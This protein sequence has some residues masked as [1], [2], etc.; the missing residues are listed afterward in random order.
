[1]AKILHIYGQGARNYQAVIGGTRAGLEALRAAIDVA[2][3]HGV[4]A[5]E[6]EVNDGEAYPVYVVELKEFDAEKMPVPYTPAAAEEWTGEPWD[7][8]RRLLIVWKGRNPTAEEA[9]NA[10]DEK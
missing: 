8:I 3:A 6:C 5:R 1:M 9:Q 10:G 7:T 4:A 2:L